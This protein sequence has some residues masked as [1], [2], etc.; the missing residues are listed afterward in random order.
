MLNDLRHAP[1][2]PTTF[3]AVIILLAIVCAAAVFAP[4]RRAAR[5]DPAVALRTD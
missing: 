5:I 1:R 4:A 3:A 2:D